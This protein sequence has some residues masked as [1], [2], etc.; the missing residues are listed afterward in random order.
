MQGKAKSLKP[1]IKRQ[2][3][4]FTSYVLDFSLTNAIYESTSIALTVL[5]KNLTIL[6]ANKSFLKKF[7]LET[8]E[9]INKSL[10]SVQQG[11][12][13][14]T[15]FVSSLKR[16]I[17][18]NVN[19]G[20]FLLEYENFH[21]SKIFYKLNAQ[22]ISLSNFKTDL[23]LLQYMEITDQIKT[24]R[25]LTV[26]SKLLDR[27]AG[28]VRKERSFLNKILDKIQIAILYV[29]RDLTI[30]NCNKEAA[31]FLRY[32]YNK[33][34]NI[35]INQLKK[36]HYRIVDILE[37]VISSGKSIYTKTISVSSNS[38]SKNTKYYLISC[39]CDKN[40]K[41]K[42]LGAFFQAQDIT[43]LVLTKERLERERKKLEQ[44]EERKDRFISMASHELRNPIT[45]ISAYLQLIE[46]KNLFK[47]NNKFKKYLQKAIS[48]V[49]KLVL[50]I[51]DLLDVSKIEEGKIILKNR[52][53][54]LNNFIKKIVNQTRAVNKD[55][56]ITIKKGRDINILG[57]TDR[58]EQV[59]VNILNNS[60][61]FSA[62]NKQIIVGFKITS[63][64]VTVFI[65]D[66][67]I[68]IPK[69]E[70]NMVFKRFRRSSEAS[71]MM[72]EGTGLGLYICKEIV[73]LH[74]GK[75]WAESSLHKGSTFYISLPLAN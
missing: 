31:D 1:L 60:I 35:P 30:K 64:F 63:G 33:L 2:E 4:L 69:A 53:I 45:T 13:L 46:K 54:N 72:I 62:K 9:V 22:K 55:F 10:A 61:K 3:D 47:K 20:G 14:P 71:K 34:A 15:K 38:H 32:K 17:K 36:S 11:K 58:L 65:Q 25:N 68:G 7:N 44:L 66:F 6:S 29:D 19:I 27:T 12:I 16:A 23:Y 48:Q 52:K 75:I 26:I 8:S 21:G 24:E 70:I 51:D 50:L 56:S 49:D 73:K 28:E 67:G 59:F 37:N 39:I 5:D 18:N 57:D 42:I 74:G 40:S 43:S 41:K